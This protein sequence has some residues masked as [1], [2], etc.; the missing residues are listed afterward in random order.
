MT[1]LSGVKL[2]SRESSIMLSYIGVLQHDGSLDIE[3]LSYYLGVIRSKSSEFAQCT[4]SLLVSFLNQQPTG[5]IW[6]EDHSKPEYQSRENLKGEW[7]SP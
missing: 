5:R 3:H 4:E 7:D 1:Y 6:V 2:D